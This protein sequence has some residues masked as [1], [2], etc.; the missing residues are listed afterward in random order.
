MEPTQ[1]NKLNNLGE[2]FL[3]ILLGRFDR[4]FIFCS[5]T[6]K[7]RKKEKKALFVPVPSRSAGED[8]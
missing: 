5:Q 7:E 6:Q 8:L 3:T 1:I 4:I 2:D